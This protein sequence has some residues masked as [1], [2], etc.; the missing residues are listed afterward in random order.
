MRQGW[1]PSTMKRM[2]VAVR[3]E[4]EIIQSERAAAQNLLIVNNEE[5][6]PIPIDTVPPL[7]HI[8]RPE[9]LTWF[10]S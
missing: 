5:D 10:D 9:D 6:R 4:S 8:R 1:L 7:G 3:I 2:P